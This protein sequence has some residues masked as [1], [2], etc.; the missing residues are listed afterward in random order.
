MYSFL[1]CTVIY[2]M[3]S[4][5]IC[6]FP[7]RLLSVANGLVQVFAGLFCYWHGFLLF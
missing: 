6:S 7:I 1:T 2:L 3:Y 4:S 5:P